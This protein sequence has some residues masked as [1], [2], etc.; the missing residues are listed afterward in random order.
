MQHGI[1]PALIPEIRDWVS[2]V[3]SGEPVIEDPSA[4]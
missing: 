4:R 2:S 1:H 3:I